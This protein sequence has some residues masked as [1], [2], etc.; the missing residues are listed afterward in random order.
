MPTNRSGYI[1]I[2][3]RPNV[4]KSTLLN[5]FLG[6]KLAITSDKA[7]T[8]R[9]TILGIKTR[10]DGQ[11]VFVDTP[12]IHRRGAGALNRYLNRAALTTI[13]EVDLVLFV[14]EAD[15]WTDEDDKA[16]QAIAEAGAP[17]IAVVNKVDRLRDKTR[18][19]PYLDRLAGRY[20][21][22]ELVPVSA[23]RGDQVERLETLALQALP[24]RE[25]LFP[26]DQITDRPERFFAAELVR[27]QLMRRY[28]EEL[29]YQTAVEIERFE[30]E[31]G[32][33]YRIHALIWVERPGQKAIIIGERGEALKAAASEARQQMQRLFERPVHLEVWVKI[34]KSWSSDESALASLGY[35]E[36]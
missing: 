19:L 12:G 36:R 26:E 23:T 7:Q 18:L 35:R 24:E 28:G 31:P 8:T 22:R 14:V 4:G 13:G 17:A 29:P 21:F 6:Q 3:G 27:E 25:P 1:A 32:G 16:L 10:P 15:R 9:H 30:E 34:R 20:A 2:I 33:R 5:G 11:L